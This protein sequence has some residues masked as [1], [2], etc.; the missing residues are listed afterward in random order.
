MKTIGENLTFM[1]DENTLNKI[2]IERTE[3]QDN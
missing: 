2:G 3:S 1:Q